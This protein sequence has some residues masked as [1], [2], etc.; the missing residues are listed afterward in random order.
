MDSR[1]V[2]VVVA[3]GAV[4]TA[5]LVAAAWLP[6][7]ALRRRCLLSGL[8]AAG[9][10]VGLIGALLQGYTV[11]IGGSAPSLQ[12]VGDPAGGHGG[13]AGFAFPV[14]AL[15]GLVLLTALLTVA[16]T[17][18]RQPLAV[19]AA[20]GGWLA[21]VALLMFAVGNRGDVLLANTSSAQIYVY[22]GLIVAFG[23][24]VL[25][26]QWQLTDRLSARAGTSRPVD[27]VR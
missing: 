8:T 14:G 2:V 15:I 5:G 22:G 20:G 18:M 6:A 1:V 23:I 13:S 3:V 24:G 16:G 21:V 12:D 11:R 25:A 19:L 17:E 7:G 26:Y 9:M 10:I 27:R 4:G